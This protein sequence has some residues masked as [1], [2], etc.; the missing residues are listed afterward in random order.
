MSLV[1]KKLGSDIV[2]IYYL[3]NT[4]V[5]NLQHILQCYCAVLNE[6]WIPDFDT[7]VNKL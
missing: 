4:R 1:L 6:L 5:V 2:V 3:R 7:V